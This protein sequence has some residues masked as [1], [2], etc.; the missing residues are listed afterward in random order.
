MCAMIEKFRILSL[1]YSNSAIFSFVFEAV[2]KDL[3]KAKL[4]C[5]L[6]K[7]LQAQTDAITQESIN[8]ET[9]ELWGNILSVLARKIKEGKRKVQNPNS[10]KIL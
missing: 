5:W 4:C 6:L 7:G 1:L 9:T 3:V 2:E 10:T 8:V